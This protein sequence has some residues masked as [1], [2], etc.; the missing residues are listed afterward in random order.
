MSMVACSS[1]PKATTVNGSIE[2]AAGLNPS[3]TQRPSPLM[4]RIYELKS[5]AAF[6]QADF[7]SLY[8]SDQVTLGADLLAKEEMML[9]PGESRPSHEEAVGRDAL[10]RRL[11]GLP[12]PGT[13][14]L[15]IDRSR[16]AGPSRRRSRSAPTRWRC[17][18]RCRPEVRR[19]PRVDDATPHRVI[20]SQGMFLQPHHFQQEARFVE[21]PDRRPRARC[22]IPTPGALAN[23]CSTKRSSPW[24]AWRLLRAPRRA[25]RR[26]AVLDPRRRRAAGAARG[27]RLTCTANW[28]SLRR[29]ARASARP[30][31]TSATDA[32]TRWPAT[33]VVDQELRDHTNAADDAETGADR[34]AAP[35]ADAPARRHRRPTQCSAS[36]ACSSAAA[37]GRSC[38]TAA[39]SRRRHASTPAASSRPPRRCCTASSSS[40]HAR[41]PRAWAS[42]ATG[43]R[44]SPTS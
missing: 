40:G 27:C 41:W 3:V 10:R 32:A 15:A 30:R 31:S 22:R 38:W 5:A 20:W 12:E 28:S 19:R 9:Q 14:H 23:W 1:V 2:A 18:R 44:K 21:S 36:R 43:C 24:A 16:A 42:S 4:I 11:R 17:R 33:R 13:G 35:E 26:H 37:T 34:R 39:T 25:A 8:Q 6:N 7:M 29:R